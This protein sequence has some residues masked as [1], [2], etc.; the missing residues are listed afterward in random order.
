MTKAEAIE[1]VLQDNGGSAS[2]TYI[3][4]NIEKYY[5]SAKTSKEWEAGIRGVL[6]RDIGK[7]FKRIGLSIYG[8]I[9]YVEERQPIKNHIRRHSFIEGICIELGNVRNFN[10]Y[11]ADPSMLYRDNTYL[12]S[13]ASLSKLPPFTYPDII[14]QAHLIDV[15]WFNKSLLAFPQYAF[16]VVDSIGTLNGALNRCMQLNAFRTKCFIVAPQ[17]HRAKYEQT[18][19]LCVY[20]QAKDTFRFID[21]ETLLDTYNKLVKGNDTLQ[22]LST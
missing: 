14:R 19:E 16:E 8:L 13:I 17:K 22:W 12:D 20:Q 5:P 4:N 2:W 10:T 7:R 1:K 11:T 21:Y 18:L 3:Y 9:D 15:L 6:Y